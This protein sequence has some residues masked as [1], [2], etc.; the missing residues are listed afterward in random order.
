[1]TPV[2]ESPITCSATSTGVSQLH[3]FIFASR[4]Y[5]L[6]IYSFLLYL[7]TFD[8]ELSVMNFNLSVCIWEKCLRLHCISL[9]IYSALCGAAAQRFFFSFGRSLTEIQADG[10]QLNYV[11]QPTAAIDFF[12]FFVIL[13]NMHLWF[14]ASE[15]SSSGGNY[16]RSQ[17]NFQPSFFGG[18]PIH[19]FL[20]VCLIY[21]FFSCWTDTIIVII[22]YFD[23]VCFDAREF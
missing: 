10:Q 23:S 22:L 18:P 19:D 8:T 3:S 9:N 16:I 4:P 14:F 11:G 6:H 1:M 2:T 21:F 15:Q 13:R 12:G 20:F 17:H 7:F 5:S